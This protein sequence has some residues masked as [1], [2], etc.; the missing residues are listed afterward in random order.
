METKPKPSRLIPD[1][2]AYAAMMRKMVETIPM[3]EE[4]K[5]EGL[6][7]AAGLEHTAVIEERRKKLH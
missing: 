2:R 1:R 3:S 6:R 7:L 4:Q 5:R